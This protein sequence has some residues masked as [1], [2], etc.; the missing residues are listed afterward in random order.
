[1]TEHFTVLTSNEG[2][3]R[4]VDL[5]C[6]SRIFCVLFLNKSCFVPLLLTLLSRNH[7]YNVVHVNLRKRTEQ[8]DLCRKLPSVLQLN[9]DFH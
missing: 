6:A 8:N 2:F 5:E 7:R 3:W 1:M 4:F 9:I